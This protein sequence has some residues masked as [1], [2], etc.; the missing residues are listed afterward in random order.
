[1]KHIK[2][3]AFFLITIFVFTSCKKEKADSSSV[4]PNGNKPPFANAGN[5]QT[6][7]LPV[8]SIKLYGS[9]GDAD[10]T[11][12][13]YLWTK[14]SGPSSFTIANTNIA[15]TTVNNLVA[16]VYEFELTVLDN[17]GASAKAKVVVTVLSGI[18]GGVSSLNLI[19]ALSIR[20]YNV[21]TAT[22]GNKIFF[23]G[24][25]MQTA[26][27]DIPV[28]S[29][30]DI[31]DLT[32]KTWSTAELSL[33]RTD[34]G[35]VVVGNKVLFAGGGHNWTGGY[36]GYIELSS[37]VDIY[38]ISTNKWSTTELPQE[39]TFEYGW[40]GT[41]AVAGNKAIFC[42]SNPF[43]TPK[44]F[45]FD[46]ITNSWTTASLSIAR[47]NFVSASVGNKVLIAGG[48]GT[49][50]DV[51]DGTTNLWSVQSLSE[52][53]GLLR[54][55]T[56]NNKAF[57]AGGGFYPQ[58][59]SKVDI[60]DN[61]T[62]TWYVANL[63]RPTVL[64]GAAAAGQ[65]MLFISNNRIDIYDASTDVWSYKD[66]TEIFSDDTVVIS[67]GGNVYVIRAGAVWRVEL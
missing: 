49:N 38:D 59:T 48:G 58:Y 42:G 12:V 18:P 32:T 61:N 22:A 21:A 33:A 67:A 26:S 35:A 13:S 56:L 19:G 37:R 9:G 28:S 14:L 65:K 40:D 50:V 36:W 6:I 16:G 23:A 17:D 45:M 7:T 52:S 25:Y 27:D 47:S 46:V 60:Y 5:P 54:G 57:F 44:A 62:Q 10:G 34:I 1:M 4:A 66:I 64:N 43:T 29:R 8:D 63:S 11:I 53:R 39:I 51:Y 41:T 55:A 20:R 3:A 30:V 24:G 31:Y 15:V 2:L